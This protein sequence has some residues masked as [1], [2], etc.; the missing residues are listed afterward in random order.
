MSFVASSATAV[1][2]RSLPVH[3]TCR[4]C[5]SLQIGMVPPP[6]GDTMLR[7]AENGFVQPTKETKI[8]WAFYYHWIVWLGSGCLESHLWHPLGCQACPDRCVSRNIGGQRVKFRK[9]ETDHLGP[10]KQE[11][12]ISGMHHVPPMQ[13]LS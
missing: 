7:I 3:I 9:L 6:K 11:N 1:A 12:R 5:R 10:Q 4:D 13:A 8:S 2:L